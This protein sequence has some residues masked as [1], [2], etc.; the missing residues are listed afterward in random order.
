MC[1]VVCQITW[2]RSLISFNYLIVLGNSLIFVSFDESHVTVHEGME[3]MQTQQ[4]FSEDRYNSVH[5]VYVN[6]TYSACKKTF[7]ISSLFQIMFYEKNKR[8]IIKQTSHNQLYMVILSQSVHW[9]QLLIRTASMSAMILK[10]IGDR[11]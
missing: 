2:I 4:P 11:R 6:D 8:C 7:Q 3:D 9:P 10:S 5:K 1:E